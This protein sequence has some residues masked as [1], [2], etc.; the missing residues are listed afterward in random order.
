MSRLENVIEETKQ[1]QIGKNRAWI[2][3]EDGTISDKVIVADTLAFIENLMPY[4]INVTDKWIID[5]KKKAKNYYTYNY[6]TSASHDLSIWYQE[7]LPIAVICLH[8]KGDA[9]SGYFSDY[10]VIKM[11]E[12]FYDNI[13][14]TLIAWYESDNES[15]GITDNMSADVSLF[16]ETY[17]VFDYDKQKDIGTYSAIEKTDLLK[18]IERDMLHEV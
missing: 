4:E 15:V 1:V 6:N 3:N 13:I 9:C 7:N 12:S 14:I 10:F 5:F 8:L 18:E 11:E 2:F 17:T 16:S